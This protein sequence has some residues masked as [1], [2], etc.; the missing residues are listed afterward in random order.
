MSEIIAE[1]ILPASTLRQF[2]G[3]FTAKKG[4]SRFIKEGKLHWNDDGMTVRAVDAS[5]VCMAN[6][7]RLSNHAFESYDSPGSATIGIDFETLETRI[8][9]ADADQLVHLAVDM[10]TNRLRIEYGRASLSMGMIDPESIRAE[11]DVPDLDLPNRAV[12]EANAFGDA[13]TIADM[14]ADHIHISADPDD[15]HVRLHTR[16]DIDDAE[17][18]LGYDDLIDAKLT[19]ATESIFS[20]SF[21]ESI[22]KPIPGDAEVELNFGNEYPVKIDWYG[23]DGELSVN[24]MTA[25]RIQSD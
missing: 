6:P 8:A 5:N 11:P 25:P 16:G 4:S 12:I 15:E 21:L 20:I 14:I 2:L 7:V 18:T 3:V 10:E 9:P 19:D 22:E 23:C 1:G 13:L 24:T 17:V